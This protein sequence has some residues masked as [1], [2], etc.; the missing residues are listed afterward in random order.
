MS[1]EAL[2]VTGLDESIDGLERQRKFLDLGLVRRLQTIGDLAEEDLAGNFETEGRR[3]GAAWPLLTEETQEHR[4]WL[5]ET[6][7]LPIGIDHPILVNFGEFKDSIVNKHGVD[8]E[9]RVDKTTVTIAST[10]KKA[11]M[12]E[13]MA[14]IVNEG[15]GEAPPRRIIHPDGASPGAMRRMEDEMEEHAASVARLVDGGLAA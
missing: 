12:S 6:W 4:D 9:R 15:K 14:A 11:G 2:A 13:P 8:H 1:G 10:H 7:G 5:I 3:F